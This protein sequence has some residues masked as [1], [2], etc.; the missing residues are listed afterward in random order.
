[1]WTSNFFH[2]I[3]NA[4]FALWDTGIA[5]VHRTD[6]VSRVAVTREA[7]EWKVQ[8]IY[9][10]TCELIPCDSDFLDD[11]VEEDLERYTTTRLANWYNTYSPVFTTS[12]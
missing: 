11:T 4:S 12:F 2:H 6:G 8:A 10:R 7:I 1:M 3:W 9:A 5:I